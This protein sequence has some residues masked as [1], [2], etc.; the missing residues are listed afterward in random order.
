MTRRARAI[1]AR[2]YL[3]GKKYDPQRDNPDYEHIQV[4]DPVR[5]ARIVAGEPPPDFV[6]P[7]PYLLSP[8]VR[9]S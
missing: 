3:T 2:P 5:M 7:L 9:G 6:G 8:L 4:P 1:S